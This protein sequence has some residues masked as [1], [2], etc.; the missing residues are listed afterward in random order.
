MYDWPAST[1][2]PT[3]RRSTRN[4]S[5]YSLRRF[6]RSTN[7]SP[8]WFSAETRKPW[9]RWHFVWWPRP[10]RC[11]H[12]TNGRNKII[13]MN[14]K[15]SMVLIVTV[16]WCGRSWCVR[17]WS[18]VNGPV[19]EHGSHWRGMHRLHCVRYRRDRR[20]I[21]TPHLCDCIQTIRQSFCY[22]NFAYCDVIHW[23]WNHWE[24]L[25]RNIQSYINQLETTEIAWRRKYILC[26]IDLSL[27]H[28]NR[29]RVSATFSLIQ[30]GILIV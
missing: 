21:S 6:Y 4:Y 19:V 10:A 5:W 16:P 15:N 28:S 14:G 20:E 27:C 3:T 30:N 25:Q 29:V 2:H 12:A 11:L 8:Q 1:Y 7:A 23:W 17:Y 26:I 13:E 24:T 18:P 22:V 9:L